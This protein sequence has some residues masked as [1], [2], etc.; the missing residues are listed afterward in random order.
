[1]YKAIAGVIIPSNSNTR[2][3]FHYLLTELICFLHLCLVI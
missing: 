1:M 2:L 3:L